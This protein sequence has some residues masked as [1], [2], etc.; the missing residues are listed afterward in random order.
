MTRWNFSKLTKKVKFMADK[1][2]SKDCV[3][4]K[5]IRGEIPACKIY[6]DSDIISFLDILPASPGHCLIV[7]K[8]H[9][10]T[11]IEI[12]DDEVKDIMAGAK[13]VASAISSA[14]G[15]KAYN[16]VMNNGMEAGQIVH[17][18]HVHVIPRFSNDGIKLNWKHKKYRDNEIEIHRNKIA[19]FL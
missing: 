7:P 18:A 5:I 15:N 16:I 3:F 13:K 6:E 1:V 9:Y 2:T 19:K 8:K 12:P 4:C 10:G 11:L 17:H 14:Y